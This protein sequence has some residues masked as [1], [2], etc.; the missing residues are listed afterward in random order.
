[1]HRFDTVTKPTI[2]SSPPS[3]AYGTLFSVT[4]YGAS[5]TSAVVIAPSS[6]THCFNTNQRLVG[7][8]IVS[9]DVLNKQLLLLAP[10]N[11][12]VAPSQYYMLFL[13]NDLVYSRAV[14]IQFDTAEN[15]AAAG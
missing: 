4:Y 14:W 2:V 15:L 9:H 6:T 13:N 5:V 8:T 12:Y 10:P 11:A 7:L 3:A 1:M